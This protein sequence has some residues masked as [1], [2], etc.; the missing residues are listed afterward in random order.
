[1]SKGHS[2][3]RRKT[4]SKLRKHFRE[5][6][7]FK[8]NRLLQKFSVGDKVLLNI[9]PS[10]HKGMFLPRFHGLTGIVQGARGKCYKV[11]IEDGNKE[12]IVIAHPA[13]LRKL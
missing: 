2:G 10:F 11:V 3:F 7:K 8:V 9:E 12:K 1:M 4:R 5:R 13:H 6:S